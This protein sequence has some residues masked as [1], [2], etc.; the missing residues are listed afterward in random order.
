MKPASN[1]T[2]DASF[3]AGAGIERSTEPLRNACIPERVWLPPDGI[4]SWR[5]VVVKRAFDILS[6]ST[7][8]LACFLPALIVAAVICL[9]S[10]GPAFYREERIGQNGR[11]FRI[12]KF[13]TM[14]VDASEQSRLVAIEPGRPAL[15]HRMVKHLQDPRITPVGIFLRRWSVDEVPQLINVLRG[16]MSLIGPRP[17]VE[18]ETCFYANLLDHYL[19]AKPGLT[20]L[21][22]VTGRGDVGY[23]QR[24]DLDVTYVRTWTFRDDLRILLRT[25]PTVLKGIGS[26]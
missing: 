5:Y 15:H 3:G 22:Q 19:D 16:E 7:L 12:W 1:H 6:A 21:W 25:I 26:R 18:A 8:L 11:V 14:R 9:T 10:K 23:S 4:R 24:V 13:R 2:L 20:G 17:I